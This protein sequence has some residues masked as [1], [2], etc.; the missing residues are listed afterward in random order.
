[1]SILCRIFRI[2]CHDSLVDSEAYFDMTEEHVIT[3]YRYLS[4]EIGLPSFE[5]DHSLS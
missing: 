3:I 2:V 1:M 5:A 4:N